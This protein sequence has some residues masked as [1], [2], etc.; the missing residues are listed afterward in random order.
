MK[1]LIDEEDVLPEADQSE[2]ADSTAFPPEILQRISDAAGSRVVLVVGAGVSM[3]KPTGLASGAYY[4]REAHRRL[5]NDGV[6]NEGECTDPDDLSVLADLLYDKFGSQ[7]A[8]TSRLPKE[9]WRTA[10][11]NSG[12]LIA[13]ALLIEGAL[14]HVI[15][16]NYDLAF[17]HAVTE[18][19]NSTNITFVEGPDEH[20]SLAS[21][22]VVHLHRSVN[23]PEETWVLR[24]RALDT[25]WA[26]EWESVIAA[27]NL[28]AP[29]VIFV[30]L[31]S[32]ANVLTESVS[33]LAAKAQSS[34]YLVDRNQDSKFHEAL[35]ANLTGMVNLYWGDFMSR[36]A[37][38]VALEQLQRIRD[39]H[40]QMVGDDPD[41]A[42]RQSEDIV[43]PIE[44][45][46]LLD[47][48][49]AR[50]TWLLGPYPYA[51]EGDTA[52]QRQ[53]AHLLVATDHMTAALAASPPEL[54]D[55]G[56]LTIRT[57]AGSTLVFGLAHGGGTIAWSAISAKIRERNNSLAPQ[58]RTNLVV[59]AGA[60]T[61]HTPTVD[62]LVR[63]NT[64]GDLIR[65]A[66]SIYPIFADD[67]LG[68]PAAHLRS[69][70][71][72]LRR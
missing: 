63:E 50:A 59:V 54:D 31:G 19:G 34:Y 68:R 22:S 53:I 23:Q 67:Y 51:G 45:I 4:S 61:T 65:G 40:N 18:L 72:E 66:D 7:T 6:L 3:E 39:T 62:D 8:L 60:R 15:T 49:R 52:N 64:T 25:D 47:L 5:V 2:A 43:T 21:H 71:E 26:A 42:L 28:S 44:K 46:E 9:A 30:G 56:R 70:V 55:H 36:L 1:A 14:R 12:H 27:A 20:A 17:Q 38:R 69:A 35:S 32:P 13:A 57:D 41:M 16:L 29:V 33:N 24:K 48:G 37:Q 10:A 58:L 11:P